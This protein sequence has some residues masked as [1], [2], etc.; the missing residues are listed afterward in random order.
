[1]QNQSRWLPTVVHR[2]AEG[3]I[4][5][6][7]PANCLACHSELHPPDQQQGFC[8]DCCDEMT[9]GDWPVC[10]RCATRV[11]KIP[12]PVSVCSHCQDQKYSFDGVFA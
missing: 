3:A 7:F 6:L 1:M 4:D 5:L 11:P 9:R 10:R 2:L 12:G 8:I